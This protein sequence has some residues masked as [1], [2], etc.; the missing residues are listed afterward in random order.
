MR[1]LGCMLAVF[2]VGLLPAAG[3]A[4]HAPDRTATVYVGGFDPDGTDYS[5]VFGDDEAEPL[6]DQVAML[7]GLPT[8]SQPSALFLPNVVTTTR[9]YGDTAPSYYDAADFADLAAV[10]AQWGGG[11]PRYALIIA[12]YARHVL[13]RSGADQINFIGASF[14]ALIV[15]WLIEKDVEHLASEGR[16]ARCSSIEGVVAGNWA[17]SQEDLAGL[18]D[19]VQSLPIDVE[20]MRS[21]WIET[22]LHTPRREA[23]SAWYAVILMGHVGSTDDRLYNR[24]LTAT[25][26][27]RSAY[28]PND[29]IQGLSDARFASMT[30]QARFLG[31][32]PTF[33][34]FHATHY[35]IQENQAAWAQMVTFITQSRRVSVTMRRATIQNL[36]EPSGPI[37]DWRPAEVVFQSRVRSP[38]V[39]QRWGITSA[40]SEL[41]LEGGA[42]PI[43]RFEQQ[44]VALE[45][46]QVV[47]D[48]FVLSEEVELELELWAEEVDLDL[49]YGV[50]ETLFTP[51]FQS[52]GS[53]FLR[54]SVMQPSTVSFQAGEWSCDLDVTVFDYPFALPTAAGESSLERASARVLRCFPNP[55]TTRLQIHVPEP[56][57]NGVADH[58]APGTPPAA[59]QIYNAAGRLVRVLAGPARSD[60]LWDGRDAAGGQLP[61]GMYY[62]RLVTP[63]GVFIGRSHR[64][65]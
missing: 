13:E 12:K 58:A 33:S 54:V 27:A 63:T 51:Y 19:L 4:S 41:T 17:A 18:A 48:D 47:F 26:L 55:F 5:G 40:I 59:L 60:F 56:A 45:F 65:H 28:Q 64:M 52:L 44:G 43:R 15:R 53:G 62:H 49:R 35:G 14:G 16:I 6:L 2:W 50:S 32:A 20:H 34:V 10:T 8:S 37:L 21:R 3:A 46:D 39:A 38:A 1:F 7:V 61:A 23:D 42:P 11:V 22:H 25:M 36:H 57:W 9:Y 29:G 31:L 30:S 24:A